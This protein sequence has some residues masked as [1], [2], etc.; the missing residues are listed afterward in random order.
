MAD[1]LIADEA[2]DLIIAEEVSSKAVYNRRYRRPEWPGGASGITIGIG[3]DVGA[4][5]KNKAQLHKDWDSKIP[6]AM[7]TVLEPC[8]G[9]TGTRARHRLSTVRAEVDVPWEA[10]ISVF[11]NVDLPRWHE[12]CKKAL[13]NFETLSSVCKG[14]LV[15]LAYNRGISFSKKGDRYTEMRKIR[16]L[17]ANKDF[18]KVPAEFRKMRRLWTNKSNRGVAIRR[19]HEARLFEKGLTRRKRGGNS[20]TEGVYD[21]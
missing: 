11:D 9:I 5:V 18:E 7:I 21:V 12:L 3:Y 19:E 20:E 2:R 17:M 6:A 4:G 8:I 15:S 1:K 14:A 10:A 13:P 16:A